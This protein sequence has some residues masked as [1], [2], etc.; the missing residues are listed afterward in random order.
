MEFPKCACKHLPLLNSHTKFLLWL[1]SKHPHGHFLALVSD[2]SSLLYAQHCEVLSRDFRLP[3]LCI[4]SIIRGPSFLAVPWSI[5]NAGWLRFDSS[6]AWSIHLGNFIL[7]FLG[8]SDS[9]FLLLR[10]FLHSH[11]LLN[12]GESSILFF[13]GV[14]LQ[15]TGP[16]PYLHHQ[17]QVVP[18]QQQVKCSS[19]KLNW[20]LSWI[21]YTSNKVS[22]KCDM[23]AMKLKVP[24]NSCH[25]DSQ[26][27]SEPKK[28][29]YLHPYTW[30]Q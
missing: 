10:T 24:H 13:Q 20:H 6:S 28:Q 27:F 16:R 14:L 19:V 5:C 25:S 17:D 7:V 8:N 11:F 21:L 29:N 4:M 15:Y 12:R 23:E 18:T 26:I 2:S 30:N 1:G 3:S 22:R 9:L